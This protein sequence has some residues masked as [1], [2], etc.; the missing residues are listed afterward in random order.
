LSNKLIVNK[1]TVTC[2]L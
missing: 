2:V 1:L